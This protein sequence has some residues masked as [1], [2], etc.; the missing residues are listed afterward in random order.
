MEQLGIDLTKYQLA[1]ATAPGADPA[2]PVNENLK[3]LSGKD[4]AA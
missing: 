4:S 1:I 2:A 3:T